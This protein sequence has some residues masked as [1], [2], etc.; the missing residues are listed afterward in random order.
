MNHSIKAT[1]LSYFETGIGL[2]GQK[3]SKNVYF[4]TRWGIHTFGVKYPIDVLILDRNFTV[5]KLKKSLLPCRLFFWKPVDNIVIELKN[6]TIENLNIKVGD[7]IDL[8]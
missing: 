4:Q 7:T 8:E 5:T 1:K 3:E 6:G 2:I